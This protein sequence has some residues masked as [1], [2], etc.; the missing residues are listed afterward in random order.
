MRVNSPGAKSETMQIV[1]ATPIAPLLVTERDG[2][3][4][5][6]DYVRRRVKVSDRKLGSPL[7]REAA[8]QLDA[9]F[10]GKLRRFDLPLAAEGSAF[11]KRSWDAIA[12]IPFGETRSYGDLAW[13]LESAPRAIGGACGRNPIPIIV[14]CHRVLGANRAI[15]GYSGNTGLPTK[16]FLLGLEGSWPVRRAA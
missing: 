3:V 16:R 10:A 6:V 15:G 8:R 14:P 7:M 5:S 11:D 9:Y 12:E 1:V 4:V 13:Q 2:A